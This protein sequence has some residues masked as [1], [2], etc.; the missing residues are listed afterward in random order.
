MR[1]AGLG[2]ERDVIGDWAAG[3]REGGICGILAVPYN[4]VQGSPGVF[5]ESKGVGD[6][7]FGRVIIVGGVEIAYMRVSRLLG[8]RR[9][10]VRDGVVLTI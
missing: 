8:R 10:A 2:E 9:W 1:A 5:R 3:G 6:R 4:P 7:V